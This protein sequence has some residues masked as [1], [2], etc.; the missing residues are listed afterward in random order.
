MS[1]TRKPA[2]RINKLVKYFPE[3]SL[4][5]GFLEDY[6]L[7]KKHYNQIVVTDNFC[8]NFFM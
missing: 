5:T 8:K 7:R 1:N 6:S 2:E 3:L 4:S